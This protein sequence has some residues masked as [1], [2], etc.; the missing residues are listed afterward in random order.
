M[1]Q[2]FKYLSINDI[3]KAFS[4]KILPFLKEYDARVELCDPSGDFLDMI[5]QNLKPEKVISLRFTASWHDEEQIRKRLA[6]CT[7]VTSLRFVNWLKLESVGLYIEQFKAL[8]NVSLWFDYEIDI[9]LLNELFEAPGYSIKRLAVH[10]PDFRCTH[11]NPGLY[12]I[13][14]LRDYEVQCLITD[15]EWYSLHTIESC[16]QKDDSCSLKNLIDFVE[17]KGSIQN[18]KIMT[19]DGNV[20]KLIDIAQ[21][22]RLKNTGGELESVTLTMSCNELK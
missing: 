14:Y 3:I 10:C 16:S 21:R 20:D 2:I 4:N 5:F 9:T 8:E 15:M 19:N 13:K 12:G 11:S 18:L 22:R 7:D 17:S 1:L 6:S